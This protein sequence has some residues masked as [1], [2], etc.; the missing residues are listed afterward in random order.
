MNHDDLIDQVAKRLVNSRLEYKVQKKLIY[1]GQNR[2]IGE[3]DL[4]ATR[5]NYQL[6]F[7]MKSNNSEDCYRKALEQLKRTQTYFPCK[8]TFLFY[9][10]PD[11]IERVNI[12]L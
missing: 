3:L 10:S 8:R 5:P 1:R 9:V 2:D 6:I 7:E 12:L 11:G 4:I